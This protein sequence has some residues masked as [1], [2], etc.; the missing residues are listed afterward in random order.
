MSGKCSGLGYYFGQKFRYECSFLCCLEAIRSLWF[1][2]FKPAINF[3]FDKLLL[4][5]LDYNDFYAGG[6]GT[7]AR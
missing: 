5:Q 1:L 4:L 3:L 7:F 6:G 2:V